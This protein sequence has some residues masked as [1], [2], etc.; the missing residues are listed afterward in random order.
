MGALSQLPR[1]FGWELLS[2]TMNISASNQN[3]FA[4]NTQDNSFWPKNI[5]EN[6]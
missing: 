5:P 3:F 4:W 6:G 2:N 1:V